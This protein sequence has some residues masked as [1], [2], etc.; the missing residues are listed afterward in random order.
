MRFDVNCSILFTELPLVR[1]A[2][3]AKAAGFSGVECWWPWET[4]APTDDEADAF[5]RAVADAGVELVSLNFHAGDMAA[6]ER[7]IVSHPART[8]EYRENV[9]AA[10]EIA[11]RT[12]C[13]RLNAPYGLRVPGVDAAEQDAVAVENLAF[14]AEAAAKADAVV[15]V[16][17]INSVDIP[18]FPVDTSAKAAAVAAQVG[19]PNI[20]L[21][22][23]LY[24]LAKMGEDVADVLSRYRGAI[25][26][27][28][29]AD[30]P[31][32]GAPGT[33]TLDFDPAFRQLAEQ[34]YDGWVGLEYLPTDPAD[35][36][37]S[38]GWL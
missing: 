19:A 15:L 16:E 31:G 28:Q 6:G 36:S 10:V 20:G 1:R 14:A 4:V 7:G 29:V 12:G 5:V 23:D 18:G 27:V 17:A 38:F 3:A 32:R 8:A 33:G 37:T 21:L 22:A 30:P 11:R 34:S 24:H 25:R 13:R 9:A 26:H 2:A 35:S